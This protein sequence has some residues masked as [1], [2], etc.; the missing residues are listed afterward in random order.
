M[1]RV[2]KQACAYSCAL[3]REHATPNREIFHVYAQ[4]QFETN[5][6]RDYKYQLPEI[7]SVIYNFGTRATDDAHAKAKQKRR[8]RGRERKGVAY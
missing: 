3:Y 5:A 8:E 2:R 6:R 7:F 1:Q 4:I